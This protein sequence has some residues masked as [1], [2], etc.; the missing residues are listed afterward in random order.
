MD[1]GRIK[2]RP[3]PFSSHTSRPLPHRAHSRSRYAY[4][5]RMTRSQKASCRQPFGEYE[6]TIAIQRE[7]I[8][9]PFYRLHVEL[10]RGGKGAQATPMSL[11]PR[12][13]T[14]HNHTDL[15]I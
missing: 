13:Y 5:V 1:R 10:Y 3:R 11:I 7:F 9:G 8:L 12:E 14:V 6:E 4:G 2:Q 15:I